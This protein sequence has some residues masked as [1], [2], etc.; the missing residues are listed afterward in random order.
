MKAKYLLAVVFLIIAGC[1]KETAGLASD[2]QGTWELVSLDDAWVGHQEYEPGN[3]NSISFSGNTYS[4]TMET[5]DST[6]QYSGTFIIYTAK[7]CDFPAV[8]G[9]PNKT[10]FLRKIFEKIFAMRTNNI[11]DICFYK[12]CNGRIIFYLRFPD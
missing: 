6:Y 3:G 2:L 4:Q 9:R 7:P 1:K 8:V 5:T 12:T 10:S 11:R